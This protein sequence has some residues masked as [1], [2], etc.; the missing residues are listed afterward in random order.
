[1]TFWLKQYPSLRSMVGS[2]QFAP[3]KS[4]ITSQQK[5][6]IPM[7]CTDEDSLLGMDRIFLFPPLFFCET[8]LCFSGHGHNRGPAYLPWWSNDF[9]STWGNKGSQNEVVGENTEM[10]GSQRRKGNRTKPR[11]CLHKERSTSPDKTRLVE[12]SR[13]GTRSKSC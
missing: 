1:M 8:R 3:T 4:E 13:E 10:G 7:L 5:W 2:L 9:C 6:S 12:V 11:R